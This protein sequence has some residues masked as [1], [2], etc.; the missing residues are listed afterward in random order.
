MIR[1]PAVDFIWG[2]SDRSTDHL[3]G[4]ELSSALVNVRRSA[5]NSMGSVALVSG[6]V[7]GLHPIAGS[8]PVGTLP[9]TGDICGIQQ[10]FP[11]AHR[12]TTRQA[13][14]PFLY[15]WILVPKEARP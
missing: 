13:V 12:A 11:T 15:L 7:R 14:A 5:R 3:L 8:V 9:V 1:P 10:I 2:M 4:G 6:G